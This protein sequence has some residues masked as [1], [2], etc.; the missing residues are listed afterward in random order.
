MN[1]VSVVDYT[2]KSTKRHDMPPAVIARQAAHQRG[3]N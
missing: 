2:T 3:L 1:N